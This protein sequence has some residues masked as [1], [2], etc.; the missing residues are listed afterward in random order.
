MGKYTILLI[1]KKQV[2]NQ[3]IQCALGCVNIVYKQI[4]IKILIFIL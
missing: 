3:E 2:V 1:I 4:Y